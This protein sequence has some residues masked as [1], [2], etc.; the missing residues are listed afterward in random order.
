LQKDSSSFS[1]H[2][3]LYVSFPQPLLTFLPLHN[4]RLFVVHANGT[5]AIYTLRDPTSLLNPDS[6][7]QSADHRKT[8]LAFDTLFALLRLS[9]API[10]PDIDLLPTLDPKTY[11]D[12][13]FLAARDHVLA[14]R[15]STLTV[16]RTLPL[17]G[18]KA[19]ELKDDNLFVLHSTS[20]DSS[21]SLVVESFSFVGLP[22]PAIP[23]PR[24]P[25]CT[26]IADPYLCNYAVICRWE[27][28][29]CSSMR[30]ETIIAGRLPV[31]PRMA[32]GRMVWEY[33]IAKY[34]DTH[35]NVS[36]PPPPSLLRPVQKTASNAFL[37][38]LSDLGRVKKGTILTW[39][40]SVSRTEATCV[41]E[42][43]ATDRLSLAEDTEHPVLIVRRVPPLS[44]HTINDYDLFVNSRSY[45]VRNT[46]PVLTFGCSTASISLLFPADTEVRG[47]WSIIVGKS[48]GVLSQPLRF[49]CLLLVF[50]AV[51]RRRNRPGR[52]RR[53]GAGDNLADGIG[54]LCVGCFSC[55][56]S[57]LRWVRRKLNS[58]QRL[59]LQAQLFHQ[60][61]E[62]KKYDP[63][64]AEF[65]QDTC[66]ICLD[67]FTQGGA[68]C[69]LACK[70]YFH[71][72]CIRGWLENK[73]KANMTCPVCHQNII[74][75][76]NPGALGEGVNLDLLEAESIQIFLMELDCE[77]LTCTE[78]KLALGNEMHSQPIECSDS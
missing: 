67:H 21:S 44:V 15:L 11:S 70:H 29:T 77:E 37:L 56:G 31:D 45:S 46:P 74:V 58:K 36:A 57:A 16:L 14:L 43:S 71:K 60:I 66:T 35:L 10:S 42:S 48:S 12:A 78:D 68:L 62:L 19:V 27:N 73:E 76:R 8:T 6:S 13:V 33:A 30:K 4:S 9:P 51:C 64:S 5:A 72:R 47:R 28:S 69:S 49:M 18:V 75:P 53:G 1:Y 24:F 65:Q 23:E 20:T 63:A 26:T 52:R 41:F 22:F 39:E 59:R 54:D 50:Y 61:M 7:A 25:D 17:P 38:D 55:A 32:T 34:H 40:L 3:L 2:Q